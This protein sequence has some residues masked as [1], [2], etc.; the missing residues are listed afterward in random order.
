[1]TKQIIVKGVELDY[2]HMYHGAE[3]PACFTATVI[4]EEHDGEKMVV[5]AIAEE[6]NETFGV[7]KGEH[8]D[9]GDSID[10]K[11]LPLGR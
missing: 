8:F 2:S 3:V 4:I 6:S 11:Y 1:M 10:V 5:G 7:E 9:P